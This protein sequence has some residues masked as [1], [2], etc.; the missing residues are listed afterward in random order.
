M[1]Y[2]SHRKTLRF[3]DNPKTVAGNEMSSATLVINGNACARPLCAELPVLAGGD[4]ASE[5]A[6]DTLLYDT[7]FK[8]MMPGASRDKPALL[9]MFSAFN[10]READVQHTQPTKCAA[11]TSML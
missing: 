9:T 11:P 2:T 3:N 5:Y 4:S 8:H 7:F 1:F 10:S 6:V